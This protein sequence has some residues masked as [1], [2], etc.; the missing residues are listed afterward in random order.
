[1]SDE[2]SA[3]GRAVRERRAEIGVT[4]EQLAAACGVS[5]AALSRIERALMTPG[6]PS[7]LAIARALGVGIDELLGDPSPTQVLR[8]GEAVVFRD[9]ESGVER[10][11][12]AHP[13]AGVEVL[14]YRLPAGAA[15]PDFAAHRA[16]TRE[17]F[18]VIE[19][20]VRLERGGES[21]E[22]SAGDTA[23]MPGDREH[24]IVNRGGS[25]ARLLLVVLDGRR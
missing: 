8:A 12:L 6:L 22:L 14:D 7:A 20:E 24:R 13:A 1:M 17:T 4:L 3:F 23:V 9:P 18:H 2:A 19:G 15:S 5:A 16:A 21:L 25:T 10:R 11:A